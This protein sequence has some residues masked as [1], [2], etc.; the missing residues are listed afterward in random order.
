MTELR[1]VSKNPL[2]IAE[3]KRIL[4]PLGITVIPI[5]YPIEELQTE[6]A[7]S[8]VRDKAIKAFE[9]VGHPLFVE[10]TGLY[11]DYLNGFPGGLT[12]IFWDKLKADRFAGLFGQVPEKSTV[13]AKTIIGYVDG[14]KI[15]LFRGEVAGTIPPQPRGDPSFQWDCVFVPNDCNKTF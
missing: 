2:K 6:D 9:Q 10:H 7:E 14:K 13:T 3:A 15:E 5:T 12:Q 1:F 4:K 11:L 8:L